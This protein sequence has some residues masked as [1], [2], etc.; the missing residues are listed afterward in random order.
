MLSAAVEALNLKWPADS[1]W[2]SRNSPLASHQMDRI[3]FRRIFP[4]VALFQQHLEISSEWAAYFCPCLEISLSVLK[5]SIRSWYAAWQTWHDLKS[6]SSITYR[7]VSNRYFRYSSYSDAPLWSRPMTPSQNRS[8]RTSTGREA[9]AAQQQ[10]VS[11]YSGKT[12]NSNGM[13]EFIFH[14]VEEAR[15]TTRTALSQ[16]PR[17]CVWNCTLVHNNNKK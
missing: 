7:C 9:G 6:F 16:S 11:P 5:R 8:W 14:C 13:T 12:W 1:C 10:L 3:N 2:L 15:V 4:F 17:R